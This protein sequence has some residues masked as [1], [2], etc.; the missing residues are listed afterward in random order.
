MSCKLGLGQ[1][2]SSSQGSPWTSSISITWELEWIVESRASAQRHWISL[3]SGAKKSVPASPAGDFWCTI[4]LENLCCGLWHQKF[5]WILQN[6]NLNQ[7]RMLA[8]C[9]GPR[10]AILYLPKDSWSWARNHHCTQEQENSLSMREKGCS[11]SENP[12]ALLTSVWITPRIGNHV[13]T[14]LHSLLII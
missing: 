2:V 1:P 3:W 7:E 5:W 11:G 10:A 14:N 9:K 13:S 8:K 6:Q 4:K 12:D